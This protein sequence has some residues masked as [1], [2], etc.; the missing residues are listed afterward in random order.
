MLVY[1]HVFFWKN[2]QMGGAKAV[3]IGMDANLFIGSNC[4]VNSHSIIQKLILKKVNEKKPGHYWF[5]I[6]LN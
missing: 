1:A 5:K 2:C 6:Y 4:H 3:F